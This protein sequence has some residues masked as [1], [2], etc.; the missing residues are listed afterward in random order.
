MQKAIY[1][2][3]AIY[4]SILIAYFSLLSSYSPLFLHLILKT[5]CEPEFF[6]TL[7]GTPL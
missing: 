5:F 3:Y 2:E 7:Q 4:N 1:Y 6:K